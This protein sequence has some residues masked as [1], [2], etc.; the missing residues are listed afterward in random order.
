VARFDDLR[1]RYEGARPPP[2]PPKTD[3]TDQLVAGFF[4]Y[5]G[6]N[7]SYDRSKGNNTLD[8]GVTRT[9]KLDMST[10][11]YRL[12]VPMSFN[13]KRTNVP[14]AWDV[15]FHVKGIHVK[16]TLNLEPQSVRTTERYAGFYERVH[17][18]I[19]EALEKM[20]EGPPKEP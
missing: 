18:A 19:G 9:I 16:E 15:D 12:L 3:F 20:A 4:E 17:E 7:E 2:K 1:K 8:G 13:M 5:L 14:D 6:I 11:K 10:E